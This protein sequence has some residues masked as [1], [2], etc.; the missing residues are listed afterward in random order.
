[1]L[2][3]E[4]LRVTEHRRSA[5][6]AGAVALIKAHGATLVAVAGMIGQARLIRGETGVESLV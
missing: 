6:R 3:G 4:V 2:P 1:M 5:H